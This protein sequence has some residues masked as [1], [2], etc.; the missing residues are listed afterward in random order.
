MHLRAVRKVVYADRFMGIIFATPMAEIGNA[1]SDEK[2]IYLSES[3]LKLYFLNPEVP[4]LRKTVF[5]IEGVDYKRQSFSG[6]S[7]LPNSGGI[8]NNKEKI[9]ERINIF[10][11]K[12]VEELG[13][14]GI[15]ANITPK[16]VPYVLNHWVEEKGSDELC[17][18]RPFILKFE[19]STNKDAFPIVSN[20]LHRIIQVQP[21]YRVNNMTGQ[22]EDVMEI[23]LGIVVIKA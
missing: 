22:S 20:I 15:E 16:R 18:F 10:A 1:K 21:S 12:L 14:Q 2:F 8:K 17:M 7:K 13:K 5:T 23:R 6:L 11:D 4:S 19:N 9:V 3:N